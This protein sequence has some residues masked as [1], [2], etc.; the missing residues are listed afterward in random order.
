MEMNSSQNKRK[1]GEKIND[2]VKK[3]MSKINEQN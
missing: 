3:K 2:L 1:T